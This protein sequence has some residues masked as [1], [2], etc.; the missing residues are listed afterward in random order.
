MMFPDSSTNQPKNAIL[1]QVISAFIGV[2]CF[3]I[4]GHEYSYIGMPFAVAISGFVLQMTLTIHLPGLATA[5]ST[6][7]NPRVSS[8]SDAGYL[9]VLFPGKF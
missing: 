9:F 3:K 2:T 7:Y 8:I 6:S 1:G 4:F 5:V